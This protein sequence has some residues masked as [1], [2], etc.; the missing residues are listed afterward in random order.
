VWDPSTYDNVKIF[1]ISGEIGVE[2]LRTV[3][4]CATWGRQS[5]LDVRESQ[6]LVFSQDELEE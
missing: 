1:I 2:V 6:F 4:G 5:G 3:Y